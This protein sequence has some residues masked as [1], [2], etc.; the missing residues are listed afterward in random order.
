[1]SLLKLSLLIPTLL[2]AICLAQPASAQ[3]TESEPVYLDEPEK[4]PEARESRREK[5]D[6]KY[7]N[8][9]I[10]IEREV[11]I[12]SD[13]TYQNDGTY[14]EYYPDSQKFCEGKYVKGVM[15]GEWNYWH[16]NG[17]LC[18]T[19]TFKSGKPDGSYQ[20]F[21]ADE[22][23]DAVQS[24]KAGIRDGE[25]LSYYEDGV[26]P[27][28][29]MTIANG[30]VVGERITYYANGKVRQQ[31]QF[32]DGQL[33]GLMTEFNEDGKKIAEATFKAGKLEGQV[34]RFE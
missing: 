34:E 28:V 7:D 20:V 16:P 25:W 26:T 1:M 14:T 31:A 17:K 11:V 21:R 8:G 18:K 23:L 24:F 30:K 5:V 2:F 15:E 4:E 10:R 22:T 19:I 9:K 13:D 3:N 33:N 27:K 32:T 29:K 12:L 6:S